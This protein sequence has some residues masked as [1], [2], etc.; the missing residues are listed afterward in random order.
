MGRRFFLLFFH[1]EYEFTINISE[2]ALKINQK[3]LR[4][5]HETSILLETFRLTQTDRWAHNPKVGGSNPSPATNIENEGLG[6]DLKPFF[7]CN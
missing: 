7:C 5:V 4:L 2:T 6:Y 3:V 1:N